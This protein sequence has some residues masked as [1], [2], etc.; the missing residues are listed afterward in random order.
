MG[1]IR[2]QTRPAPA[3]AGIV[4]AAQQLDAKLNASIHNRFDVEVVD[5]ET[6]KIKQRAQAENV[7]CNQ[8]WTQMLSPAAY[9]NYIH[10]G[11][12]SGTPAASD[13]SLFTF[14]GYGLPATADDVYTS[15]YSAGIVSL[16]RKIQ[17]SETTA[18]GSIFTEIGIAY[19][20]GPSTLCTHAM[21]KDANGNQITIAKTATDIINIYATVFLNWDAS[22]Y[23]LGDVRLIYPIGTTISSDSGNSFYRWLLGVASAPTCD[24][25]FSSGGIRTQLTGSST[26]YNATD[27]YTGGATTLA[28]SIPARTMTITTNRL[29]A[30]TAN[31]SNGIGT[32]CLCMKSQS[33]YSSRWFPYIAMKVGGT[34]YQETSI[35]G[36]A[37]GTGDGVTIDFATDFDRVSACEIMVNGTKQSSEV[38]VDLNKPSAYQDMGRYFELLSAPAFQGNN[39]SDVFPSPKEQSGDGSYS[40]YIPAGNTAIYCNPFYDFGIKSFQNVACTVLVSN[41]LSTWVDITSQASSLSV[42]YR[43]CKY[44]KLVSVAANTY[45]CAHIYGLV[46]DAVTTANNI[47]FATAPASGAVI[48]ADYATKTIAKDVNHVFDLTVTIQLGEYTG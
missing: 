5:A 11:T 45:Q 1:P 20:A 28:Y 39:Y 29:S 10:Y 18:V 19:S 30:D 12:G 2:G 48:T 6:G 21:L 47:H 33:S 44:W 40:I 42:D 17:I 32:I 38:T 14:L 22:Q 25:V 23:N 24:V 46:A 37:I 4:P 27:V 34:W 3:E 13:T 15:D 9:F 31:L 7:I 8:L 26:F 16:Q 43:K 36:E 35:A 41:D